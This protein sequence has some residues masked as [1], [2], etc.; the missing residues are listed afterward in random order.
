MKN[1]HLIQG[2]SVVLLSTPLAL[3]SEIEKHVNSSIGENGSFIKVTPNEPI[4]KQGLDGVISFAEKDG[5]SGEILEKIIKALKPSGFVVLYEP[6]AGRTSTD[7][8]AL[9]RNLTFS[10]FLNPVISQWGEYVEVVATKPDWEIGS[11]QKL[12]LKK[13]LPQEWTNKGEDEELIDEDE[14]LDEKDRNSRPNTKRDDCEVGKTRKACKN[15][16]CGRAEAEA[17]PSQKKLTLD[18]LENPG[19]NSGCGNCALGDAFRCGGCPYRGL[20]AY[21]VGEPITL[22]ESFLDDDI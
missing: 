17:A 7:S 18:M 22:P 9:S 6:L 16:T 2:Q 3:I 1:W 15:C 11:A 12:T 14:L 4:P 13:K 19:V 8:E 5:H 20:P 21:K 10:G